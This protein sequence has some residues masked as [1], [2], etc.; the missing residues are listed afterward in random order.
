M[1]NAKFFDVNRTFGFPLIQIKQL[2]LPVIDIAATLTASALLTLT[3]NHLYLQQASATPVN[4]AQIQSQD[5]PSTRAADL[6]P[7]PIQCGTVSEDSPAQDEPAELSELSLSA[8]TED[9]P[10]DPIPVPELPPIANTQPTSPGR[11]P[12]APC[13]I[14]SDELISEPISQT[15]KLPID[16]PETCKRDDFLTLICLPINFQ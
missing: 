11:D 6:G 7:V 2:E 1:T 4:E 12:S 9:T 10:T 5:L 8:I 15:I 13:A 3:L 14:G 16:S